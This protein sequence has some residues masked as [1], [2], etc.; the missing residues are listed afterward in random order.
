[1]SSG[2]PGKLASGHVVCVTVEVTVCIHIK[3]PQDGV[4]PGTLSSCGPDGRVQGT[5]I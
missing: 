3:W 4:G 5:D 2:W 1:M